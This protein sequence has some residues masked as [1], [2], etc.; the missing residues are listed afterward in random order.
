MARDK[1][2]DENLILEK[3]MVLFWEKGYSGTSVQ[4]MVSHLNVNRSSLYGTYGGKK[5]LYNKALD[6]YCNN[7]NSS[8]VSFLDGK[9]GVKSTLRELFQDAI[10]S[11]MGD[12]DRKGCFVVNTT[13]EL[14]PG[15]DEVRQAL[16]KNKNTVEKIFYE[17]LLSG[18][19]SGEISKDKDTKII[20]GLI[21]V[22]LCGI[23]VAA[24]KEK[25][26]KKL[27]S[28]VDMIFTLLD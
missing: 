9:S 1:L 28:S 12:K 11:S 14:I 5:E 16:I 20:A 7:C 24:K 17:F 21:Y 8:L 22:V 15:D 2:F 3:A 26:K 18:Q 13:T 19:K 23:N 25:N 6:L 10:S 27:L 4:D